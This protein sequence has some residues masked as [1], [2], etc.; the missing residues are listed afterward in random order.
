MNADRYMS[1]IRKL[2]CDEGVPERVGLDSDD[3]RVYEKGADYQGLMQVLPDKWIVPKEVSE[4]NYK[5]VSIHWEVERPG[6]LVLHCE[7]F[8]RVGKKKNHDP[9]L[10]T[11]LLKLKARLT[12]ELRKAFA[13][14]VRGPQ[15][16]DTKHVR[17]LDD[18]SGNKVLGFDLRLA[19]NHRPEEAVPVLTDLL[20]HYSPVIDRVLDVAGESQTEARGIRPMHTYQYQSGDRPL[21]G[22]TIKSAAGHGGFGEVYYAVSDSGREVALKA[23]Q[24]YEQIELRGIRQCMNLK[25]PHLVTIFDVKHNDKNQP[26]VLMEYVAGPSLRDLIDESPGGLGPQKTAFFLREIAKGLSYLHDCGIVHRDLKPANI[27][28]E[29][30][31]V[32][33]GDYGLSKAINADHHQSQTVTVGTVH[34]MAPEVGAGKYDRSIDIYAMG[35]MVY[36][37]LTGHV[38]FKGDTPS[39]VLMKHLSSTPDLDEIEEPFREAIRK[40]MV[41]DPAKRYQS[42]NEMVETIFGEERMKQSMAGF[43]TADLSMV[44]GQVGAK[45]RSGGSGGSGGAAAGGAVGVDDDHDDMHSDIHDRLEAVAQTVQRRMDQASRKIDQKLSGR[46]TR[47]V[48]RGLVADPLRDPM[49]PAQRRKLAA[50]ALLLVS[51][52]AGFLSGRQGFELFGTVCFAIFASFGALIGMKFANARMLSGMQQ[53]SG[54]VR[55]LTLGA[56]ALLFAGLFSFPAQ[57][58]NNGY[59]LHFIMTL[60]T[61]AAPLFLMDW[62]KVMSPG[63]ADRL[64]LGSAI[65]AGLLAWITSWF[66]D[67]TGS[68]MVI[69]IPVALMLAV[70]ALSPFD[71]RVTEDWALDDD[72]E[73]TDTDRLEH[74]PHNERMQ[75]AGIAPG[76]RKQ[77][78]HHTEQVNA[79]SAVVTPNHSSKSRLVALL[80]ALVPFVTG[81]PLFGIHRFYAGKTGTGILWLLTFGLFGVGQVIDAILIACGSF[82]DATGRPM[83]VWQLRGEDGPVRAANRQ[84]APVPPLA[85]KKS[86]PTHS[87]YAPL[88]PSFFSIVL[89]LLATLMIFLAMMI[90]LPLALQLPEAIS[91]NVFES[92]LGAELNM[93]FGYDRWPSL[94]LNVGYATVFPLLVL[95]G[96][97]LA[98]ARRHEGV[99]HM[100][101]ALLGA[102]GIFSG[103]MISLEVMNRRDAIN[104]IWRPIAD[105]LQAN[106]IGPAIET[107]MKGIEADAAIFVLLFLV[108][109]IL[110]LAWPAKR[111]N[112]IKP[113]PVEEGV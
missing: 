6:Y 107:F 102:G 10:V 73:K 41:K 66:V 84:N 3:F 27:F 39:E 99:L 35:V 92:G 82:N 106:R 81:F 34:Y 45:V 60:L 49:R 110:I 111:R 32:K 14:D 8:P 54:F 87:Y 91:A 76:H 64:S 5:G 68:M 20:V 63:R 15:A 25:S 74:R 17:K 78:A 65:S 22:Y 59:Q 48:R 93:F 113:Q 44:A 103:T 1:M 46:R 108:S 37:M 7:P 77:A 16:F 55:R 58:D 23:V 72:D 30:G 112:V 104:N 2:L 90:A 56:T 51:I 57:F 18:I 31:Y 36:E 9:Q 70:Q 69:G 11:G 89:S 40:A 95:G 21:E 43:S 61:L 85:P 47:P 80:L 19:K 13:D 4:L 29:N 26:F 97:L 86:S 71:P 105:D 98:V 28:Y 67:A 62:T 101:R 53:E 52:G 109:S 96:L 12:E 88:M 94:F 50:I 42:I 100:F 24:G 38:P 79:Y 83:T 33:I 75:H